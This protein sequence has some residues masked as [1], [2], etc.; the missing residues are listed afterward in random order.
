M[1]VMGCS[2]VFFRFPSSFLFPATFRNN[3]F[4]GVGGGF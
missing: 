1:M 3:W 2:G 4:V